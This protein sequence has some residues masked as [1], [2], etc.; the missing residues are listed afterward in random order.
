MILH[1]EPFWSHEGIRIAW[2]EC[3]IL[4]A[5]KVANPGMF[6]CNILICSSSSQD[7]NY[8]LCGFPKH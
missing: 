7:F 4:F 2:L 8:I 6:F 5:D 3:L 1:Q